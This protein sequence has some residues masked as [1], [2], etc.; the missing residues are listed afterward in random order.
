[1][2]HNS[3]NKRYSLVVQTGDIAYLFLV[4]Y[5]HFEKRKGFVIL[6]LNTNHLKFNTHLKFTI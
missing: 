6:S 5:K 4:K 2:S 1:L 3:L